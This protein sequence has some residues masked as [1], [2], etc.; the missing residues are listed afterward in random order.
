MYVI[1]KFHETN[2]DSDLAIELIVTDFFKSE[3]S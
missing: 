1:F 2:P 3:F